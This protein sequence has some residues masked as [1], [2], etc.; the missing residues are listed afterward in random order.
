[1]RP[2]VSH[3]DYHGLYIAN[4][5]QKGNRALGIKAESAREGPI[6]IGCCLEA[7]LALA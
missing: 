5:G 6:R 3:S 2:G 7:Q 4:K 1:M